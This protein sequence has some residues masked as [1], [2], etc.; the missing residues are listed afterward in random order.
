MEEIET[1]TG[2]RYHPYERRVPDDINGIETYKVLLAVIEEGGDMIPR[3]SYTI[4]NRG[5]NADILNWK[6]R[7]YLV[8]KQRVKGMR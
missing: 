6:Y 7:C 1:Y 2:V 4:L 5:I 8:L 3:G